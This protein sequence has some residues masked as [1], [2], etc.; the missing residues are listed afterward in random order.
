[1]NIEVLDDGS[2]KLA[3]QFD[4]G[5][6]GLNNYLREKALG[7]QKDNS[8]TTTLIL[9]KYKKRL[10]IIGF[11]TLKNTSLMLKADEKLRGYP[12][13]EIVF[14]AIHKK[15]QRR[16][17][18][19]KYLKD[20]IYKAIQSS[21]NFSAAKVLILSSLNETAGFYKKFGFCEMNGFLEM[22]YDEC[23]DTT[24]P[25]FLNLSYR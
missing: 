22:L 9:K 17:I 12:A 6:D 3:M 13:I 24:T 5:N 23:R 25:M 11:Y 14:F 19:S 21:N 1:M 15:Y 8:S 18:G 7:D 16:G 20:I 2:S 4:C 10:S